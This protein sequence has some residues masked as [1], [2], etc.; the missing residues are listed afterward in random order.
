MRAKIFGI[1]LLGAALGI[2]AGSASA[3][4]SVGY[5]PHSS[6]TPAAFAGGAW[7]GPDF[8][9]SAFDITGNDLF[10]FAGTLS[11]AVTGSE[12]IW[13]TETGNSFGN[14]NLTFT[15]GFSQNV[16]PAGATVAETTYFDASDAAYGITHLLQS[17]SF[18]APGGLGPLTN[19]FN[20]YGSYSL[21]EE[22]VITVPLPVPPTALSTISL[23][24]TYNGPAP[25]IP[26]TSTWAMFGIGFAGVGLL[27]MTK[28]RKVSRYAL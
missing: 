23:D 4:I 10:S 11:F 15:S 6:I 25:F 18:S 5:G 16:L 20:V 7:F 9:A 27:G 13:I 21:T 22:Y 2:G 12:T 3:Q 26:E 19:T 28:R 17:A 14:A 1:A 24:T 8:T